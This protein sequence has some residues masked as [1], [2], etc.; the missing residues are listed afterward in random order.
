LSLCTAN[1]FLINTRHQA[2]KPVNKCN[3]TGA[4]FSKPNG[5][6]GQTPS[7]NCVAVLNLVEIG[8]IVAEICRFFDLSKML[9]VRHLGFVMCVFGPTTNLEVFITVQNLVGLDAVVLIICMFFVSRAWLE[10]AYSRPP[11]WGFGDFNP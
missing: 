7:P 4:R 3:Y 11:N 2:L 1:V 8:Q 5:K 9:A 10:N 6:E